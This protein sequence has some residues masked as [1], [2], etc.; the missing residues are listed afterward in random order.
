MKMHRNHLVAVVERDEMA[1]RNGDVGD[2]D[3]SYLH[4]KM[5]LLRLS[6]RIEL[7]E[8]DE[9]PD[10][11]Q[12]RLANEY[13]ITPYERSV[14]SRK[15]KGLDKGNKSETYQKALKNQSDKVNKLKSL[16]GGGFG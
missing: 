10:G 16:M 13:A 14:A 6:K 5:T 11:T 3:P 4:N 1:I 9:L 12:L 7:L 2:K 8:S 15:A